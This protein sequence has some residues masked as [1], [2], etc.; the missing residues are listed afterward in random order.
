[1]ES[2]KIHYFQILLALLSP[3]LSCTP[4]SESGAGERL[5]DTLHVLTLDTFPINSSIRA[6]EAA[7]WL[8]RWQDAFEL[9]EDKIQDQGFDEHF[10]RKW[11]Y[12]FEYCQAAFATRNIS[13]V[14]ATYS[15]PNNLKLNK[16]TRSDHAD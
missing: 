3:L 7:L 4:K 8:K 16:S 6:L 9:N 15:R 5:P 14:Q 1:M 13:V 10:I 2:K 11:K 12:Y